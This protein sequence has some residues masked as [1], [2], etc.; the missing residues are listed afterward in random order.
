MN[1]V[2]AEPIKDP[3]GR[4]IQPALQIR[5]LI[6]KQLGLR[7]RLLIEMTDTEAD[8]SHR[9]EAPLGPA[10]EKSQGLLPEHIRA[11]CRLC[12]RAGSG[13]GLE[14]A[15]PDLERNRP[16]LAMLGPQAMRDALDLS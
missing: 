16:R 11:V 8:Q 7:S 10:I 2:P 6:P 3:V 9:V 15:E 13:N 4:S 14:A 5:L 1:A 12:Q